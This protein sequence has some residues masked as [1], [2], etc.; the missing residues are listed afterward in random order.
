MLPMLRSR[1]APLAAVAAGGAYLFYQTKGGVKE[2]NSR[3]TKPA[4]SQ[5]PVS[6]TMQSMAGTGGKHTTQTGPTEREWDPKATQIASRSPDVA[7][8][9]SAQRSRDES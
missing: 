4:E 7:S 1:A 5:I 8:K 9:R 3:S 6:E 2:P